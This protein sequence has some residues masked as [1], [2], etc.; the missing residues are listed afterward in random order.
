LKLIIAYVLHRKCPFY[1]FMEK[2]GVADHPTILSETQLSA[3]VKIYSKNTGRV[4]LE[5]H[6]ILDIDITIGEYNYRM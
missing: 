5:L 4:S 1:L 6:L 2:V 3:F